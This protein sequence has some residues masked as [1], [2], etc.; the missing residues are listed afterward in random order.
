MQRIRLRPV[1]QVY[2]LHIPKTAG[3]SLFTYLYEQ[4]PSDDRPHY[5][6]DDLVNP[7]ASLKKQRFIVGH[8]FNTLHHVLDRPPFVITMMREPRAQV[9]SH[10]QHIQRHEKH[11]YY[12]QVVNKTLLEFLRDP[13]LRL[14]V[15]NFQT[16]NLAI[17]DDPR[18]P[19]RNLTPEQIKAPLLG[20]IMLRQ[21]ATLG[22]EVL[23]ARA[24]EC[25]DNCAFVG[26]TEQ[27][28]ASLE[29]LSYTFHWPL[30][31]MPHL[32]RSDRPAP[33]LDAETEA[34]LDALTRLDQQVY[35]YAQVLMERRTREM[36]ADLLQTD[37]KQSQRPV[38]AVQTAEIKAYP[39]LK[40]SALHLREV[41]DLSASLS[42]LAGVATQED[43]AKLARLP[44]IG[45]LLRPLIRLR[46]MGQFWRVSNEVLQTLILRQMTL[47]KRLDAL[48]QADADGNKP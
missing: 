36:V 6:V 22:D 29:L 46:N 33:E 27:F 38:T 23:V 16:M 30:G 39:P 42:Y 4:M 44:V 12:A 31:E 8:T 25:L 9:I 1:D 17:N 43:Y 20:N 41:A 21:A 14:A 34:E 11:P 18:E 47:L 24:K 32:N 7:P 35:A 40:A 28:A 19:A 15:Y 48:D 37:E 45:K 5:R 2:F 26:I 13:E 3:T 10:Y